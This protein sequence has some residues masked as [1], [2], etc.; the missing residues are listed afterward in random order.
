MTYSVSEVTL[1][2]DLAHLMR[3]MLRLRLRLRLGFRLRLRLRLRLRRRL[4]DPNLNQG[5]VAIAA[6]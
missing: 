5:D 4:G 3:V 6:S 2:Q 1:L